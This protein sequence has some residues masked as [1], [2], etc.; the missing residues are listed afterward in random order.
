MFS[1]D[2]QLHASLQDAESDTEINDRLAVAGIGKTPPKPAKTE[3]K[4]PDVPKSEDSLDQLQ[5]SVDGLS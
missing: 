2:V 4:P 1:S 3:I 5:R